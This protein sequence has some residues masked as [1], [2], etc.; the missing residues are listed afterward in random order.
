MNAR[1]VRP[2]DVRGARAIVLPF[3]HYRAL[4]A[5]R[6]TALAGTI[7]I[8]VGSLSGFPD[9]GWL[10]ASQLLVAVSALRV[11]A[12]SLET[13]PFPQPFHDGTLLATGGVWTAAVTIANTFDGADTGTTLIVLA[14]CA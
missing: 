10:E 11:I 6:R 12:R 4:T 8:G 7:A 3:T 2:F 13:A 14:G 5:A 1:A 9:F